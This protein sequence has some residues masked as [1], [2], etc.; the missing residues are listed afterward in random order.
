[1]KEFTLNSNITRD[2]EAPRCVISHMST[3]C[4]PSENT[5]LCC[6]GMSLTVS[7]SDPCPVW[8]RG[9][10][11]ERQTCYWKPAGC[12]VEMCLLLCTGCHQCTIPHERWLSSDW[13]NRILS[14]CYQRVLSVVQ[15]GVFAV[16][17]H[18]RTVRVQNNTLS[19]VSCMQAQIFNRPL[20]TYRWVV[21]VGVKKW[22][23]DCFRIT[24]ITAL[25]VN[26]L[27]RL[28]SYQD[29]LTYTQEVSRQVQLKSIKVTVSSTAEWRTVLAA[30]F[31]II[32]SL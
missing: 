23:I 22:M 1:M 11:V 21:S 29:I 27:W 17:E 13:R 28:F 5:I 31:T 12:L 3:K 2:S 25:T 30:M 9:S 32:M 24:V 10:I 15:L 16:I 6:V 8:T 20:Y 4:T 26:T 19:D 14:R 7:V 18:L